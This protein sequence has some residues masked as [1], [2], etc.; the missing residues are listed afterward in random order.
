MKLMVQRQPV[1]PVCILNKD[2][3]P[4]GAPGAVP[5]A[6]LVRNARPGIFAIQEPREHLA[7]ILSRSPRVESREPG[8]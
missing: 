7:G 6:V 2:H 3:T 1:S 8:V 4:K 5:E